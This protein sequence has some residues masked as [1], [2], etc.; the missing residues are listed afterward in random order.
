MSYKGITFIRNLIKIGR[1]VQ[2]WKGGSFDGLFPSHEEH[3]GL[4]PFLLLF[5]VMT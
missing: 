5:L 4:R 1:L 3:S 2:K